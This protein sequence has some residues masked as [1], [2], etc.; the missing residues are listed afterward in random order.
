RDVDAAHPRTALRQDV[1]EALV[2]ETPQRLGDRKARDAEPLADRVL[3]DELARREGEP[4]DRVADQV[5]DLLR[6]VS[7]PATR[8][9]RQEGMGDEV[10]ELVGRVS[11]PAT[12]QG[13]QEGI[14]HVVGSRYGLSR[15]GLRHDR[16]NFPDRIARTR[17]HVAHP[18]DYFL[19]PGV[20]PRVRETPSSI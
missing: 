7:A 9:G 19:G 3:A 16:S 17:L 13:R 4:D 5:L 12:R 8:Q 11:G 20:C 10:V 1:D 18:P 2:G 15:Y 6:R 14:G